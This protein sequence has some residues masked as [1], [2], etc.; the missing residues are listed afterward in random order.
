MPRAGWQGLA[1]DPAIRFTVEHVDID[2]DRAVFRWR[3]T[4]TENYRGVNLMRVR[5]G[6]IVEAL[7][8]GKRPQQAVSS[9]RVVP[10][11]ADPRQ[12]ANATVT[13]HPR[14][15]RNV[16]DSPKP[17]QQQPPQEPSSAPVPPTVPT[18]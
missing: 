7:R 2:G 9:R 16:S 10:C 15:S 14:N 12:T 18:S 8:Y 6:K 11:S 1:S 5:D 13:G 17:T 3:I 4:G